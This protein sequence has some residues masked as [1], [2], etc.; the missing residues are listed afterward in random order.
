MSRFKLRSLKLKPMLI[1]LFLIV[2]LI[3]VILVSYMAYRSSVE[4]IREEVYSA[5]DMYAGLTDAVLDDY[6]YERESDAL[7]FANSRDVYQSMNIL[8]EEQWDTSA[9]WLAREE[10]LDHFLSLAAQEYGF[11]QIFLTCP[12]GNIVYDSLDEIE[13]ESIAQRDYIQGSLAGK[14]TWSDLFYS[15]VVHD[16][17]LVYSTP[18]YSRGGSGELVG[19]LN[20][21]LLEDNIQSFVQEGVH[22]LG[23]TADAYL[24][25]EDGLLLT[26]TMLGDYTSGAALNQSINT[27]AV[28]LLSDPIRQGNWD[29]YAAEEYL[30]Y[31]GNPVLGQVEVARLGDQ[32]V[33]LVVEIDEE[34]AFAGIAE[35]RNVMIAIVLLSVLVIVPLGYFF[36]NSIT[37]PV[38]NIVG[39]LKEMAEQGGDLTQKIEVNRNDELGELGEAVNKMIGK[40]RE[41]V[42]QAVGTAIDVDE[43]S[44]SLSSAVESVS[45]SLEQVAAS[46]N[47]FA[48][49]TQE[50]S[51]SSQEMENISN[52]V[53]TRAEEGR[54][55][56]NNAV[57]QMKEINQMVEN[58]GGVIQGLDKRSQ[59]IGE[60]VKLITGVADQT[61][62]LALNAAIEAARAGEQGRGFA[63]VAEE[64]RKLAEQS[65][66]AAN[67][68]ADL[69]RATQEETGRAVESMNESAEKVSSGSEVIFSSGVTFQNIIEN[70]EQVVSKTNTVSSAAEQISSA[71]EEIAASTEEQSST[72]EEINASA[73]ELR[74]LAGSLRNALGQFKYE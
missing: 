56:V 42:K 2:S 64:V 5:M 48:S 70:V 4:N 44:G 14:S 7:V 1:L 23:E 29:F 52:E 62:L 53:S 43:S 21:L 40:V 65:G 51:S 34:E 41:I 37:K 60:I 58:L 18:V 39:R 63:V 49:S 28:E 10:L 8:R 50:L 3:P 16:I 32:P 15:D 36:A 6:F 68:I 61:N 13:G 12:E 57:E 33:G 27:R 17:C 22:E 66:G 9:S 54:E 47:E 31:L 73:E 25:D 74:A 26:D 46:T 30:D 59:D 45:A 20:I 11:E 55:A 24:I 38:N 19:S 71:S 35:M 67:D 69:V 72:M